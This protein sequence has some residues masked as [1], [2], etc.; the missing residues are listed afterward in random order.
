MLKCVA[1]I[2]CIFILLAPS[3]DIAAWAQAAQA[4]MPSK[5]FVVSEPRSVDPIQV[6]GF[7]FNDKMVVPSTKF[8]SADESWLRDSVMVIRNVS[9]RKAVAVQ[10]FVY[11]PEADDGKSMVG[12][13][14]FLG[15]PPPSGMYTREG[16]KLDIPQNPEIDLLPGQTQ[17]IPLGIHFAQYSKLVKQRKEMQGINTCMV[18]FLN[19]YFADGTK[20][21]PNYFGRPDPNHPG[22]YIQMT[23][24]EFYQQSLSPAN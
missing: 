12:D 9:D 19:V 21:S 22:V 8:A 1:Q 13:R 17:D 15:N 14:I 5:S 4:P 2:L 16:K 10:L 18:Q 7:R 23:P 24:E 20:W 11:F 6:L 3:F